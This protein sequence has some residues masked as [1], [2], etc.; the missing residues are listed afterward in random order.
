MESLTV[1]FK[2]LDTLPP[3]PVKII[4][5]E[6]LRQKKTRLNWY[7]SQQSWIQNAWAVPKAF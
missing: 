3:P 5:K 4:E 6:L 1:S 7:S 2:E